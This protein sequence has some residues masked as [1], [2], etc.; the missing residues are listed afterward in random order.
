MG[1]FSTDLTTQNTAVHQR[2]RS[3]FKR[4][5]VRLCRF[6]ARAGGRHGGHFRVPPSRSQ[7]IVR[8]LVSSCRRAYLQ[9]FYDVTVDIF[10]RTCNFSDRRQSADDSDCGISANVTYDRKRLTVSR[11]FLNFFSGRQNADGSD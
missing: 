4:A 9:V 7:A 6:S 11:R 1:Q 8:A 10:L 2:N 3:A 5:D